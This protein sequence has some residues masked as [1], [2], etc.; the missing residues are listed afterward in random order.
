MWFR[1]FCAAFLITAG[2]S[3]P[4]SAYETDVLFEHK[5][6]K[7]DI[8]GWDDGEIGCR[9]IVGSE[10]ESF[11]IWIFQ[12]GSIQLQF[13]STS[14]AFGAE[15]FADLQL[16]I[17]KRERWDLTNARLSQ[18]SVEFNLP[19]NDAAVNFVMEIAQGSKLYLR[20]KGGKDV[21]NYSLAG[22]RAS[23]D[24][25]LECGNAISGS[26][27]TGTGTGTGSASPAPSNPF[28]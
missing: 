28:K 8:H 16:Q 25:L 3:L 2:L 17:D 7:V 22:S 18:N 27:G 10:R 19:D 26:S 6:W 4:A 5:N 14:W 20:A 21:Q 13:F 12:N 24:K 23:I 11:S 1:G 9:A 15:Q